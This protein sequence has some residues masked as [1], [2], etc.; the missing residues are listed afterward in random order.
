[1]GHLTGT[2]AE[3]VLADPSDF[4]TL[5]HARDASSHMILDA[6][7]RKSGKGWLDYQYPPQHLVAGVLDRASDG[8][9]Q[10]GTARMSASPSDGVVKSDCR[11]HEVDNL[12]IAG[13][14]V[15]PTSG[16]A[17]PTLL[18]VALGARLAAHLAQ[19]ALPAL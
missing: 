11:L 3:L 17:N 7:L 15:F 9:H 12:F 4:T 8:Y 16:Q 19:A 18:A 5:H 13:S 6:A 14:C 1:M 10:I 2:I